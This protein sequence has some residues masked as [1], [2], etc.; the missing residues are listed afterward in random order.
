[1]REEKEEEG[2]DRQANEHELE[3]GSREVRVATVKM[4][5]NS[6]NEVQKMSLS[7]QAWRGP[8]I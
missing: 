4:D 2:Y 8:D 3:I 6:T 7:R 1:V 5:L